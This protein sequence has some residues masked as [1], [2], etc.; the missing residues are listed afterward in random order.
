MFIK[1]AWLNYVIMCH[2]ILHHSKALFWEYG[3]NYQQ[4]KHTNVIIIL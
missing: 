3:K 1:Q 4:K 2:A